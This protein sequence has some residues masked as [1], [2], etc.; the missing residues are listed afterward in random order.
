MEPIVKAWMDF[1]V[2]GLVIAMLM[3]GLGFA[4]K[5]YSNLLKEHLAYRDKQQAED[6]Q[7]IKDQL[8]TNHKVFDALEKLS[9]T[10]CASILRVESRLDDLLSRG[11]R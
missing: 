7:T 8:E 3:V 9:Q 10:T 1:G 4:L 5:L 11:R 6:V 2:M